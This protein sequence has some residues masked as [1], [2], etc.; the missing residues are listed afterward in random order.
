MLLFIL[1]FVLSKH[2][3]LALEDDVITGEVTICNAQAKH[4]YIM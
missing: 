3:Y 2:T 4:E 1:Y